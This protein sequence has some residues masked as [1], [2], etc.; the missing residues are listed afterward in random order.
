MPHSDVLPDC[1]NV[2]YHVRHP[3]PVLGLTRENSANKWLEMVFTDGSYQA[4]IRRNAV[5]ERVGVSV[6]NSEIG[7]AHTIRD[8]KQSVRV[9][10]LNCAGSSSDQ[11]HD[12]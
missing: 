1:S 6:D 4:I 3:Y 7:C 12:V 9:S 10:P 5:L 2:C 8:M 11:S